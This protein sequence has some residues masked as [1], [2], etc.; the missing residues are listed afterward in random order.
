MLTS[1][2][3]VRFLPAREGNE[4]QKLYTTPDYPK[5]ATQPSCP[6]Q[7][8]LIMHSTFLFGKTQVQEA[9][10]FHLSF[11]CPSLF[12]FPHFSGGTATRKKN[13]ELAVASMPKINLS[14]SQSDNMTTENIECAWVP[15]CSADS[16]SCPELQRIWSTLPEE[17]HT[18][19]AGVMLFLQTWPGTWH[20]DSL[21]WTM[22]SWN[23]G[24]TQKFEIFSWDAVIYG[25]NW[26][27]KKPSWTDSFANWVWIE[28]GI[29]TFQ[30]ACL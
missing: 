19:K 29:L 5:P 13:L 10:L 22:L 25:V 21:S 17:E 6:D 18:I 15:G 24:N 30:T 20:C 2:C 14:N 12:P 7:L 27:A 23:V 16:C 3:I 9:S 28:M 1:V 4:M 8:S 11:P 26:V